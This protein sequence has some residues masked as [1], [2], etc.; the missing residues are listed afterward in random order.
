MYIGI[1]WTISLL[2]PYYNTI[3]LNSKATGEE[4]SNSINMNQTNS[5]NSEAK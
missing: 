1:A 4:T 3:D 2:S 5:E